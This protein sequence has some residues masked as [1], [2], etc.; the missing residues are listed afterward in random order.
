MTK[1]KDSQREFKMSNPYFWGILG[2]AIFGAIILFV[3]E[4]ASLARSAIPFVAALLYGAVM[5]FVFDSVYVS[6][7]APTVY[8]AT[9]IMAKHQWYH[10]VRSGKYKKMLRLKAKSKGLQPFAKCHAIKG[11]GRK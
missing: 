9:N 3:S 2:A 8:H 11:M 6:K 5:N 4:D 7:S 10:G 1:R